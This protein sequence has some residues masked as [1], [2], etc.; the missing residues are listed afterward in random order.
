MQLNKKTKFSI[1][2]NEQVSYDK[3][4]SS[5][6]KGYQIKK[7]KLEVNFRSFGF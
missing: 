2:T 3:L 5:K 7:F 6:L 1:D 4:V